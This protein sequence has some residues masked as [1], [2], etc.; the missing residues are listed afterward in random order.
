MP[1]RIARSVLILAALPTVVLG[2]AT[3][4]AA[5]QE[6]S[7]TTAD[8]PPPITTSRFAPPAS[9]FREL[10]S[11]GEAAPPMPTGPTVAGAPATDY[12]PD[13]T[14]ILLFWSPFMPGSGQHLSNLDRATRDREGVDGLAIA[15]G[16]ED[17]TRTFLER[18]RQSGEVPATVV[19]SM[20]R[21]RK[22]FLEP[23]GI[24]T[25]PAVVAVDGDGKIIY[26]GNANESSIA[27]GQIIGGTWDPDAYRAKAIEWGARRNVTEEVNRLHGQARRGQI[28]IDDVLAVLDEAIALDPRNEVFHIRKFDVLLLAP[29]RRDETYE[30]GREI[31]ARF[32]KSFMTLNDLA[33][34][35]VSYPGVTHRDLDFALEASRRSN[36]LQ[37]WI[38]PSH[39]DTLA[40]VHW[41]RGDAEDA[42]RWQRL[43]A[44]QAADTW[45]GD[46]VRE[47]L[48]VYTDG[49]LAPG[50]MPRP[51]VSPRRPNRP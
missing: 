16:P 21:A 5:S 48:R 32:P 14:T 43:A 37:G 34:H 12:E 11:I 25:L 28:S 39:L 42:V 33:W 38:D 20:E 23:L 26:H 29:D 41:L 47:N 46:D 17:R 13:S 44:S 3:T 22:T 31:I 40:R 15:F 1:P 36:A 2:T 10:R 51:Y 4:M 27:L 9:S 35:V 24:S 18:G 49:S 8:G 7:A 50:S 45:F 19:D 30:F 6:A